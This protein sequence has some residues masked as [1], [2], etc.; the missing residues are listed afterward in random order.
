MV[1]IIMQNSKNPVYPKIK[2]VVSEKDGKQ[3]IEYQSYSYKVREIQTGDWIP[4]RSYRT[5]AV[6]ERLSNFWSEDEIKKHYFTNLKQPK[7]NRRRG[8]FKSETKALAVVK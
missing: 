7:S 1:V 5:F 3:V 4:R 8:G 2:A 6:E